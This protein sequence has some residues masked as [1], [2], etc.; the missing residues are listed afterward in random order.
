MVKLRYML[1]GQDMTSLVQQIIDYLPLANLLQQS[2]SLYHELIQLRIARQHRRQ[3]SVNGPRRLVPIL[4]V[5]EKSSYMCWS[6]TSIVS[7]GL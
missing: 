2:Q 4:C 7:P 3:H 6:T 1:H 5:P